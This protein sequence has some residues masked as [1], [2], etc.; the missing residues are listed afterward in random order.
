MSSEASSP[1][2]STAGWRGLPLSKRDSTRR[3]SRSGVGVTACQLNATL[4]KSGMR[5]SVS[6][7]VTVRPPCRTCTRNSSRSRRAA[8]SGASHAPM[9]VGRAL[10]SGVGGGCRPGGTASC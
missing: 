6:S 9:P 10:A 8:P 1:R 4:G 2:M 7:T 3:A 5:A